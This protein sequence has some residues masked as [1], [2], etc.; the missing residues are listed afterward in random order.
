MLPDLL[1]SV[2][3]D[4]VRREHNG[5][6]ILIGLFEVIGTHTLPAVHPK[7]TVVNRWAGGTG[8][9]KQQIRIISG[10]NDAVIARD[11]EVGFTLKDTR[12]SHTVV[13]VF[14]GL[15]FERSGTYWVET[16]L[17]GELKLRYPFE[18]VVVA[19][20]QSKK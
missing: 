8:E 7:L 3:C 17:M 11:K 10:E 20:K 2:L 16:L 13:S 6:F 18:V 9:Y 1:F 12:R 14:Q 5:K 4:E 15:R 19:Q